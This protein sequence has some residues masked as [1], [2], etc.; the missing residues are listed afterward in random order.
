MTEAAFAFS[1]F[2]QPSVPYLLTLMCVL[3]V[4]CLLVASSD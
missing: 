2:V 4:A 1:N 3:G